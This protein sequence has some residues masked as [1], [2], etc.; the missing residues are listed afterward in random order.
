ML[1]TTAVCVKVDCSGG[2]ITASSDV[3]A[4]PAIC[5]TVGTLVGAVD[6]TDAVLTLGIVV[7][8]VTMIDTSPS[9]NSG[10]GVLIENGIIRFS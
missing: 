8:G 6:E 10:G 3:A 1:V 5:H 2:L 4:L 7:G 9:P